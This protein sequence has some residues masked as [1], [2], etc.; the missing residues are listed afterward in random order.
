MSSHDSERILT[1]REATEWLRDRTGVSRGIST[2][3]KW[4][5]QGVR[6]SILSSQKIGGVTYVTP[7]D[8]EL[9]LESCNAR[10]PQPCMKEI[11]T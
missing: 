3:H 6:G 9:F 2:I 11:P 10:R 5:S 1:I 4:A 8:L 7:Q